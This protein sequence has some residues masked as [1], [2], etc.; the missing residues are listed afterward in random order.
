MRTATFG[1]RMVVELRLLASNKAIQD[2]LGLKPE[3]LKAVTAKA[4]EATTRFGPGV[5]PTQDLA[6]LETS[7]TEQSEFVAKALADV[8]TAEQTIR[9][10][11]LMIQRAEFLASPSRAGR[12]GRS[13][14]RS[15]PAR[16]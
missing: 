5:R 12:S 13:R 8:L 14:P 6:A 11:E 15:L 9:F 3:Q 10:R 4:D 2:D 16:R 1:K 7:M